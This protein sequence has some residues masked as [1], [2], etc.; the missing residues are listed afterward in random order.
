LP[1]NRNDGPGRSKTR[2]RGATAIGCGPLST[3]S[4]LGDASGAIWSAW[5]SPE[6]CAILA[7]LHR[8][9]VVVFLALLTFNVSGLAAIW[10]ETSCDES[11]PMDS[12]GGQ[13]APNC[14]SCNCCSLPRVAAAA[15]LT[16]VAPR[17]QAASWICPDDE[18]T[19]PE[20]A[21]ILHVPKSLA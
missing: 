15:T 19:S 4:D 21:D 11:C 20:P 10:G 2:A 5:R 16:L 9:V 1:D 12:S 18:L 13:C 14:H 17:T 7:P 6:A 3:F 8:V